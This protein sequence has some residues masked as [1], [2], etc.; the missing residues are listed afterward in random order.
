M[1]GGTS[2]IAMVAL[3]AHW[4][5][6][7]LNATPLGR[8]RAVNHLFKLTPLLCAAALVALLRQNA[9]AVVRNHWGWITYYTVMGMA[10]VGGSLLIVPMVGY[11]ARDDVA[12]RRNPAAAFTIL[13]AMIG[14]TLAFA[15]ANFGDGPSFMVVIY[16]AILST[17]GLLF[18]WAIVESFAHVHDVITIDRHVPAGMRMGAFLVAVGLIVGRSV[19]GD[20]YGMDDALFDFLQLSWPIWPLAV[21]EII[22][23]RTLRPRG[24]FAGEHLI[25]GGIMPAA[26]HL[27]VAVVYLQYLGD[28]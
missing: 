19:A 1:A 25:L 13:G 18:I 12:E 21:L 20:W 5:N 7:L 3:W 22:V 27:T 28:W 2:L 8:G 14:L 26:V 11:S 24:H 6:P 10:W 9:D 4:Y 23:S 16:C 17:A 15:G